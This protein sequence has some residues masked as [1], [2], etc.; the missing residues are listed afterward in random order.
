[1]NVCYQHVLAH[2][3][4][5]SLSR[6]PR[7]HIQKNTHNTTTKHSKVVGAGTSIVPRFPTDT[8]VSASL[9]L[10]SSVLGVVVDGADARAGSIV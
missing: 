9:G 8:A 10:G 4:Q 3:G 2:E 5:L 6:V 1:M 7:P